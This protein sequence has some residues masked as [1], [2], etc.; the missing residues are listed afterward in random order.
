MEKEVIFN[1]FPLCNEGII[2]GIGF[3]VHEI[4]G[5]DDEKNKYLLSRV[6]RD[7]EEMSCIDISENFK[8]ILPKGNEINGLTINSYNILLHNG[9]D[10]ILYER[11]FQS[12]DNI[13]LLLSMHLNNQA[14]AQ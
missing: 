14:F 12:F 9:T 3:R 11:I 8:V 2:S 6:E 5:T 7:I 13:R 4:A 1:I 10:G